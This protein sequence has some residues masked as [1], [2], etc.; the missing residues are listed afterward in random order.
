MTN[1]EGES[2]AGQTAFDALIEKMRSEVKSE[3]ST[4]EQAGHM[5]LLQSIFE[6]A[7]AD[8]GAVRDSVLG[9]LNQGGER[10]RS[11]IRSHPVASISAAFTAGYVVG[12]S[13]AAKVRR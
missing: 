1:A 12:K 7:L 5:S 6:H 9:R 4:E 10:I 3:P 8:A 13:I 11:E 2:G